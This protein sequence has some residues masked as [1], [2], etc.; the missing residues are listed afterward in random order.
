MR[1]ER[2]QELRG[3]PE[4]VPGGTQ[5]SSRLCR[6]TSGEKTWGAGH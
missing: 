4:N 2:L 5:L 1:Q 6:A 3:L